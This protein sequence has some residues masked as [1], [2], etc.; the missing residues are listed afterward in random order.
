MPTR[1]RD[2]YFK[3]P[4]VVDGRIHFEDE[5][6]EVRVGVV[7]CPLEVGEG[8]DFAVASASEVEAY[9]KAL[10]ADDDK[11]KAPAADDKKKKASDPDKS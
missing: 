9:E 5:V 7:K 8:G 11:K 2:A 6:F 10:A 3:H 1:T 4:S